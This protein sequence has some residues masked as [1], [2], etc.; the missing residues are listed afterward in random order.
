M[1]ELVLVWEITLVLLH[2]CFTVDFI[3]L[4]NFNGRFF[5]HCMQIFYALSVHLSKVSSNVEK[6]YK[7]L[8]WLEKMK[9]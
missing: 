4:G 6:I 1:F 3:L 2:Y 9:L 8:L 7:I 5:L